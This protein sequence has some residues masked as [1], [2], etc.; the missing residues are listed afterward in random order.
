MFSHPSFQHLP[1]PGK[2]GQS[3]SQWAGSIKG[4][5]LVEAAENR[6]PCIQFCAVTKEEVF[7]KK[8]N[9]DIWMISG[10]TSWKG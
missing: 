8:A 10:H 7:P 5:Q 1:Y 9:L 2:L 3:S 4:M 6:F